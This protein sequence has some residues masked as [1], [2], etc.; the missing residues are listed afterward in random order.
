[1]RKLL[2]TLALL[3]VAIGVYAQSWTPVPSTQYNHETIVYADLSHNIDGAT[4]SDFKVAAFVLG[5]CRAEGVLTTNPNNQ[6]EQFF[7]LNV[8]GDLTADAN[9]NIEFKV[10]HT[11]SGAEYEVDANPV[12][13]FDGE[14]HIIPSNR[15]QLTLTAPTSITINYFEL[16]P[17]K[18]VNLLDYVEVQPTGA[19]LPE[20]HTWD[21]GQ[22]PEMGTINGDQFTAG[23]ETGKGDL[24]LSAGNA[25]GFGNYAIVNHATAI[26]PNVQ[27]VT[28]K[29]GAW[30]ELDDENRLRID[31]NGVQRYVENF[32]A[33][34]PA[35]ATDQVYLGEAA[36]PTILEDAQG[37]MRALKAGTTTVKLITRDNNWN[38]ALESTPITF[39]VEQPVTEIQFSSQEITTSIPMNSLAPRLAAMITVLPED[40]TDKTFTLTAADPT[41]L[42]VTNF[43]DGEYTVQA[44]KAGNTTLTA[45]ARDGSGVTATITVYVEDPATKATFANDP[46]IVTINK[47]DEPTD[48]S[49]QIFGNISLNGNSMNPNCYIS[50]ADGG[51]VSGEG[52]ITGNGPFGGFSAQSEGTSIVYVALT[53][54][55][56]D[57]YTGEGDVPQTTLTYSFEVQV[58]V[59]IP[60]TGFQVEYTYQYNGDGTID[61]TPVP[62]NATFNPSDIQVNITAVETSVPDSWQPTYSLTSGSNTPLTYSLH[63]FVPGMYTVTVSPV[64]SQQGDTYATEYIQVPADLSFASGWQWRSN[65]YGIINSQNVAQI[66]QQTKFYEA[67]TQEDLLINDP[68]W[69]YFGT[70]L[71]VGIP[72][73]ACYKLKMNEATTQK[74]MLWNGSISGDPQNAN[75][76][77]G[78]TWVG[79]PYFYD[80]LLSNAIPLDENDLPDGTVIISKSGGSAEVE[81]GQWQGDLTVLKAGEGYIVYNPDD[82]N[83]LYF[84]KEFELQPANEGASAPVKGQLREERVWEY[85]ASQFMNNMTMVAELP[86]VANAD[87]YSIGA[88]VGDECRGEGVLMNGK[89]FVTIHTDGSE[90]VS[91]KLYNKRLGRYYDIDETFRTQTRL[92]SLKAPV[93]LHAALPTELTKVGAERSGVT[94]RYD[95]SGRRISGSQRGVNIQRM[96]DGTVRKVVVK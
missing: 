57:A 78:W 48:I 44:L 47:T 30:I 14:S 22:H 66:F 56:W 13:M 8:R 51:P 21:L 90:T 23:D 80:R 77:N 39:I 70:L 34:T 49:Q 18:T 29:V 65:P 72:Q 88:F 19:V 31:E 55:N 24:I 74:S 15:I 46:L 42:D 20:N 45:T 7:V 95:L 64:E 54:N 75:L 71:S 76:Q 16:A 85:D 12:V 68:E 62:E 28:V 93:Q 50:V 27:T 53:Y 38:V 91:L 11:P 60:L 5:E 6:S 86:Q 63:T 36:D 17:G 52:R 2:S 81:N 1:M 96:A 32:Y 73:A 79:S 94:E 61:L 59:E 37:A 40:A 33:L 4:L 67:R 9:Q 10:F 87:D 69:G 35:D 84:G 89:A 26:T 43:D 82:D 92:G 3:L 83:T 25:F 58:L 41:I